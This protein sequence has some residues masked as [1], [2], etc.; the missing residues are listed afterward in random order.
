MISPFRT[1]IQHLLEL[2]NDPQTLETI[3]PMECCQRM[4][5]LD[6]ESHNQWS[7]DAQK[8][9]VSC[10]TKKDARFIL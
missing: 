1:I 5:K 4:I 8:L 6:L 10:V 2:F 7:N 3:G 9:F